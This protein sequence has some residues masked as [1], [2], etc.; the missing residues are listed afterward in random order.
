MKFA[1]GFLLLAPL[2][3]MAAA[4]L[5]ELKLANENGITVSGLG[6]EVNA[7]AV[8]PPTFPRYCPYGFC[9][10]TTKCCPKSCCQDFARYCIDGN[11][12]A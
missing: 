4:E 6:G 3:N 7:Q 12:Y 11:C 5:P 8:C 10:R 1:L 9:C 2:W